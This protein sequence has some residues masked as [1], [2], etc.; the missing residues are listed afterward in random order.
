M[1]M[2]STV[3]ILLG[4]AAIILAGYFFFSARVV[5]PT[6]VYR[7]ATE[8]DIVVTSVARNGAELVIE[9]MARGPWYFEA[10]FPIEVRDAA[11]VLVGSGHAEAQSGW[12]TEAFV[13]FVS[14]VTVPEAHKGVVHIMLKKDN[15]SGLPEYDASLTYTTTM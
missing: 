5:Q 14:S 6:I 12:M 2:R 13:P 4:I 15:P 7:N 8:H 11:G 9:G 1:L 3:S 10:S